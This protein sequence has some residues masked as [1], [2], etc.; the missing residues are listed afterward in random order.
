MN[1]GDGMCSQLDTFPVTVTFCA[2][3]VPVRIRWTYFTG[4]SPRQ[5]VLPALYWHI[6][7]LRDCLQELVPLSC[8]WHMNAAA[9]RSPPVL[10][11][12]H[13]KER[14]PYPLFF[15]A[16]DNSIAERRNEKRT[17]DCF[18]QPHRQ[19]F[20]RNPAGNHLSSPLSAAPKDRDIRKP[21][22]FPPNSFTIE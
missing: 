22:N 12:K 1:V 10:S 3:T 17:T 8:H 18:P 2:E 9:A 21:L 20:L 14:D 19:E 11:V 5:M 16:F 7:L 15:G 13:P 6:Q 4:D